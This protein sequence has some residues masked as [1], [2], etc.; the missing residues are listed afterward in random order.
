MTVTDSTTDAFRDEILGSGLLI[1]G[2]VDGLYGRSS[3]Y[4]L[5]ADAVEDY[6]TRLGAGRVRRLRALPSGPAPRRFRTDRLLGVV[7][8][9]DGLGPFLRGQ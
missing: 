7:P 2:P 8:R 6:V 9:L 5:V 4:E 3:T 1:A